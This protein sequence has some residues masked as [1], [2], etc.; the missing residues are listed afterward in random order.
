M[1][2]LVYMFALLLT[3]A[4]S[5]ATVSCESCASTPDN[6]DS[7]STQP[8]YF[9]VDVTGSTD[10]TFVL[11]F[12]Y[13][14]FKAQGEADVQLHADNGVDTKFTAQKVLTLE[15]AKQSTDNDIV[16]A[17]NELESTVDK[18]KVIEADGFY[19]ITIKGKVI[20]PKT[21]IQAVI[22]KTFTNRPP[23]E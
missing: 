15:E 4:F 6:Q 17:A 5:L 1:K 12:P 21:G 10:G 22:D 14:Q 19:T 8:V 23:N 18:F 13:G 2:K 20:E 16:K 9:T 11:E 7:V 3:L